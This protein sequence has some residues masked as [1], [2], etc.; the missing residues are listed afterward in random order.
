MKNKN[1]KSP[2]QKKLKKMGLEENNPHEELFKAIEEIKSP[3]KQMTTLKQVSEE[4]SRPIPPNGSFIKENGKR[5]G[6]LHPYRIKVV[7]KEYQVQKKK[8]FGWEN[9]VK[10]NDEKLARE[11]IRLAKDEK[12]KY[13]YD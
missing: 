2:L 11:Y 9:V 5:V 10:T 1:K 6:S 4:I 8:F 12:E 3:F 13:I 7:G